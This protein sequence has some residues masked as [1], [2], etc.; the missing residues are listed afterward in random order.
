MLIET[1]E[2]KSVVVGKFWND[3][4]SVNQGDGV[5]FFKGGLRQDQG[6]IIYQACRSCEMM[7]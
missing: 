2:C 3:Q 1:S 6:T 4:I 7:T 5:I